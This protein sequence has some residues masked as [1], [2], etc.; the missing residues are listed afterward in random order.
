MIYASF[1]G[2]TKIVQLLLTKPNIEINCKS[3]LL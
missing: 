1:Y 3:I 2:H